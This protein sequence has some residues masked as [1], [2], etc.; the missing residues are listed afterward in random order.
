MSIAYSMQVFS[1]K[2]RRRFAAEW[3][4]AAC[5][6]SE[7][8][9][10]SIVARHCGMRFCESTQPTVTGSLGVGVHSKCGLLMSSF[11]TDFSKVL[12]R[13]CGDGLRVAFVQNTPLLIT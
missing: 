7:R 4:V 5:G 8:F 3:D 12:L 13:T 6:L 11:A 10:R 9:N 1:H 2:F